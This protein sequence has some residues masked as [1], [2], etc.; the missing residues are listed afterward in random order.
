[1]EWNI[2]SDGHRIRAIP[3]SG[4]PPAEGWE[5]VDCVPDADLTL[6]TCRRLQQLYA[7]P[8]TPTFN[9]AAVPV[10]GLG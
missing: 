7:K 10:I 4:P 9:F 6:E 3:Y 1:M 2:Y 5:L 8:E